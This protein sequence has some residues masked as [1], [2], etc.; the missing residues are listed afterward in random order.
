MTRRTFLAG[1]AAF[2]TKPLL[3]WLAVDRAGE[4]LEAYW[5][6]GEQ[7]RSVGSLLK[8]FLALAYL[9]NHPDRLVM[10][11]KGASAGCWLARGHGQQD[12]V[13]ALANSCNAYFLRMI[14]DMQRAALDLTCLSY[15]LEAPGRSW[16]AARLIGLEEG[17]PQAPKAIAQ[18]FARVARNSSDRNVQVIL[19]GM[20]RCARSG[21]ARAVGVPCFAK[22]GTAR[23][24]HRASGEGD[25]YALAMYPLDL[26][27]LLVLV[28][29]HNTT[30]AEAAG[31]L[32]QLIRVC[33]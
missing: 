1:T 25:G 12:I 7:P 15:G 9:S 11:C 5:Q 30:G 6:D 14:C 33:A 8:P 32:R 10:E 19:A 27:R 24:G 2:P 4:T 29:R 20:A 13:A 26:P 16:S 31:E 18:G 22:T 28:M 3:S 23:C 17:W 21:T